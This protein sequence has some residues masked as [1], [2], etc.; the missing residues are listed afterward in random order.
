MNSF[1]KKTTVK[2]VVLTMFE[3]GTPDDGNIGE[4]EVWVMNEKL[5]KTPFP[6]GVTDLYLSDDGLLVALTGVGPSNAATTVTALALDPRFD[7]SK[8][9]WIVAG[10]AGVDPEDASIGSAAWAD[11]VILGD[12]MHEVDSREIPADWEYGKISLS[13]SKPNHRNPHP[14]DDYIVFKLNQSLTDWAYQL[15]RDDKLKDYPELQEF[16]NQFRGYPNAVKPP[17]VLKG[18]NLASSTYWHGRVLTKWANDWVKL[19]TDGEG[20]FV[21]S[22]MEDHGT[23]TALKRLSE[24]GLVDFDRLL[25]LRTASNYTAPPPDA[26]AHWHF[27]ARFPLGGLP[28]IEAAYQVGGHVAHELIDNWE[29]YRDNTPS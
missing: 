21:M 14:S 10:I 18:T 25:V 5:T 27:T 9:Y 1:S 2:V 20:N 23:V 13:S 8:A 24:A 17:F 6:L 4:L 28:S 12:I 16:R 19:Y 11:Y 7:L 15:T 3:K 29:K 26:D 22:N